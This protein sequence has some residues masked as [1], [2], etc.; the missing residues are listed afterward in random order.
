MGRV[1]ALDR[2]IPPG[3]A[4]VKFRLRSTYS[5]RTAWEFAKLPFC[6]RKTALLA[7]SIK[8]PGNTTP[9]AS[10]VTE[11]VLAEIEKAGRGLAFSFWGKGKTSRPVPCASRGI[12]VQ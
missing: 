11:G 3:S 9:A 7:A 8:L 10:G 2:K 12:L 5:A 1:T 6:F 4:R